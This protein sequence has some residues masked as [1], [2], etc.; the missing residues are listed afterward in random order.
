VGGVPIISATAP[1]T[2]SLVHI[3]RE[4]PVGLTTLFKLS[5]IETKFFGTYLRSLNLRLRA[6]GKHRAPAKAHLKRSRPNTTARDNSKKI[7]LFT[8]SYR[9]YHNTPQNAEA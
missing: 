1:F 8:S 7:P 4:K 5:R 3:Y 6:A 2:T 9:P